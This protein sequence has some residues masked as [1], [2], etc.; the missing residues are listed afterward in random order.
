MSERLAKYIA[1]SGICSRRKA[2]G[3]IISG[4]VKVNDQVIISPTTCVNNTDQIYV[5]NKLIKKSSRVRLWR[6][7]KPV[8]KITTHH[9]PQ[10]RP[11]IFDD[12]KG[13]PRVVSIGRLDINSEGLL[14]L[15]NNGDY[16][17]KM[18]LPSSKIERIYEVRAYGGSKTIAMYNQEIIIDKIRYKPKSIKLIKQGKTNSWYQVILTEGKNREIR[19][20]FAYFGFKINR[21]IR[22]KYGEYSVN[23]L[24]LGECE[25]IK[26]EL[27]DDLSVH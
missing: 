11:T 19:K 23:D 2:E 6:Y 4:K 1:H 7:Y 3:L 9:D 27:K 17:R 5:D 18:T 21:L 26:R 24:K 10:N 12:L 15:T 14:L 16:A 25:E 8:G 22:V 13:L 20:I